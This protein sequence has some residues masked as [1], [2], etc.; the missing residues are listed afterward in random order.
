MKDS[1]R[2]NDGI[3]AGSISRLRSLIHR[4]FQL[5]MDRG[6]VGGPD[7][8]AILEAVVLFQQSVRSRQMHICWIP[9]LEINICDFTMSSATRTSLRWVTPRPVAW[10]DM[11][12]LITVTT[13][14]F[15]VAYLR[16]PGGSATAFNPAW[17][18]R[19]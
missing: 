9:C 15:S 1:C 3:L 14:A 18:P 10:I 12:V 13:L 6:K 4:H 16:G 7:G 11:T 8:Q 19:S 5:V 2:S 17:G